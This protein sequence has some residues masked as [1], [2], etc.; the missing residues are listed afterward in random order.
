MALDLTHQTI[1]VVEDEAFSRAILVRMLAAMGGPKIYQAANGEEAM[2]YLWTVPQLSF[3]IS[4][5]NMPVINGLQVL[6]GVRS[7]R[8]GVDRGTPFAMLTG[9]SDKSLVDIALRLDVNSFVIKPVSK[10]GLEKRLARLVRSA[11]DT[12]WL[13][14]ADMYQHIDTKIAIERLT[15]DTEREAAR[16]RDDAVARLSAEI[17][18]V[19][20]DEAGATRGRQRRGQKFTAADLA[21]SKGGKFTES[22]LARADGSADSSVIRRLSS[23]RGRFKDSDL[24]SDIAAGISHLVAEIGDEGAGDVVGVLDALERS[25]S[26]SLG[27]I[28]GALGSSPGAEVVRGESAGPWTEALRPLGQ[29]PVGAT[30]ARDIKTRDGEVFI[31]AGI[32]MSR[33]IISLLAHLDGLKVL[34]LTNGGVHVRVQQAAGPDAVIGL[35]GKAVEVGLDDIPDG[36]LLARGVYTVDGNLYLPAGAIL[37]PRIVALLQDLRELEKLTQPVWI[38]A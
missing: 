35:P 4:D 28:A 32:R 2:Q 6:K 17:A 12:S 31:R 14:S 36:A 13:K 16:E 30:L 1:L 11:N 15:A 25:G 9:H 24:A 22:D 34:A 26:L 18:L 21:A 10:E 3:V 37:T 19:D 27:D 8:C 7:G 20:R 5:L 33:L 23:L 38:V 29:V